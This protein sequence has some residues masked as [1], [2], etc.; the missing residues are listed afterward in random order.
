MDLKYLL[1]HSLHSMKRLKISRSLRRLRI[2]LPL[3]FVLMTAAHL[4]HR[5]SEGGTWWGNCPL[6][7]RRCLELADAESYV[8]SA[9]TNNI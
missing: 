8:T 7:V 6:S 5:H 2:L 1:V 3:A 9:S 4:V